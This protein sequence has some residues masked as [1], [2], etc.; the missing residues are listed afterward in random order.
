M[1]INIDISSKNDYRYIH[2]LLTK[3]CLLRTIVERLAIHN[4]Q[5]MLVLHSSKIEFSSMSPKTILRINFKNN[6]Q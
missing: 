4:Q 6:K 1:F 3:Q 5:L 2:R